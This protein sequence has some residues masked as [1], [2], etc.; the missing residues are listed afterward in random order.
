MTGMCRD[1]NP[2]RWQEYITKQ[3]NDVINCPRCAIWFK[4]FQPL[5]TEGDN[6]E[7]LFCPHCSLEVNVTIRYFDNR[8]A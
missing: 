3:M 5:S 2:I 8:K 6:P 1:E 4:E 7:N